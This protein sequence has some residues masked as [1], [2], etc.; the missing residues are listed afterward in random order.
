MANDG[1]WKVEQMKIDE[2]HYTGKKIKIDINEEVSD[3][4]W[5]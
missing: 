3:R 5:R 2:T 4:F 1:H